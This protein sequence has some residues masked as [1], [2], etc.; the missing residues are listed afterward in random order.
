MTDKV[1]DVREIGIDEFDYSRK[2][3]GIGNFRV[4]DK[5]IKDFDLVEF[6]MIKE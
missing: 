2:V 6:R 1:M 5:V 3:R 4:D